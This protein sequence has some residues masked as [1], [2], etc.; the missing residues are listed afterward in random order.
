MTLKRQL[1][2]VP[3]QRSAAAIG[4]LADTGLSELGAAAAAHFIRMRMRVLQ[5]MDTSGGINSSAIA[6]R[7]N[8]SQC[9]LEA[10]GSGSPQES[11]C[12]HAIASDSHVDVEHDLQELA[13]PSE[14]PT[15]RPIT[16]GA[17]ADTIKQCE[18]SISSASSAEIFW[19]M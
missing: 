16:C 5:D 13:T 9:S 14:A 15:E 17:S 18:A 4:G 3:V 10:T 6:S 11:A 2:A 8:Q 7:N 19:A 12:Q 1:R